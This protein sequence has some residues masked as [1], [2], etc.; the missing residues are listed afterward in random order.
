MFARVARY[1]IPEENLDD[2]VEGFREAI[3][4]LRASSRATRAA[5]CSSTATTAP[6]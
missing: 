1:Q 4:E 6:H 3:Q 5:T 2:A